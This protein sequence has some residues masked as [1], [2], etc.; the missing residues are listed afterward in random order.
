MYNFIVSLDKEILA[1]ILAGTL[2][3]FLV[4]FIVLFA[5]LSGNRRMIRRLNR[6]SDNYNIVSVVTDYYSK[7]ENLSA[8]ILSQREWIEKEL[9]RLDENSK[10]CIQ[11]L[12]C[13]RYTAF[14]GMGSQLSYAVALLDANDNGFVINSLYGRESSNT[15]MKPIKNGLSGILLS[16]EE[17]EALHIAKTAFNEKYKR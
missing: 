15:Y 11:K 4:L 17:E 1:W 10:L 7:V 5:K 13:I 6:C 2:V 8:N 12:G 16:N 14:E 9:K 3:L